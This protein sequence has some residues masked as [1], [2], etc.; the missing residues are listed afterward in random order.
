MQNPEFKVIKFDHFKMQTG[1]LSFV[2]IIGIGR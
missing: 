2:L 1:L